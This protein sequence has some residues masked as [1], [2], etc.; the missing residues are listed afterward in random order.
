[1]TTDQII[2]K[3]AEL[4]VES[5]K[6]LVLSTGQPVYMALNPDGSYTISKNVTMLRALQE[7]HEKDADKK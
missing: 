6:R 1:M 4:M 2:T 7:F 5:A 3:H